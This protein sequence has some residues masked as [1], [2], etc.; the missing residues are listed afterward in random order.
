[1]ISPIT[2]L[3]ALCA[4]APLA[5]AH[6]V[7]DRISIDGELYQGNRPGGKNPSVIRPTS[8]DYGPTNINSPDMAC[9]NGAQP[10]SLTA[11]ARPGSKVSFQWMAGTS[12]PWF[13]GV[14]PM[15]AYMA[16]C[17]GS[18]DK[19]DSSKAKWFKVAE[20]GQSKGGANLWYQ[21]LISKLDVLP[22]CNLQF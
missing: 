19:F 3:Y 20:A 22:L 5:A 18:C 10:A 1:M 13:H 14:G 16:E 4:L 9:G 12:G 2:V 15:N 17:A 11:E 21:N 7:L 6:G 8:S